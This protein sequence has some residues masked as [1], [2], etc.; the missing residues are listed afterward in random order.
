MHIAFLNPQGNFDANDSYW[1]EHADFGGQLVYVKN[2]AL[3]LAALGHSVDIVTRQV[4]DSDWPEFSQPQDGYA[5]VEGLRI[6]RIP[7]GGD[8]FVRKEDLWPFLATEWVPGIVEFYGDGPPDAATAHYGDGGIAAALLQEHLGVPY[9][10]TAHSLGA[11]KLDKLLAS[12][13]SLED[14]DDRYLFRR[15][16]AAERSAIANASVVITS[17]AQER[18]QQYEHRAYRSPASHERFQVVPP[19]VSLEVFDVDARAANESEV[20]GKLES[21]LADQIDAGRLG[22]PAVVASSRLDP[23]KNPAVLIDALADPELREMANLVFVTG[24][25]EDPLHSDEGAGPTEAAVLADMRS[26]I[27]LHR[28]EG[29]VAAVGVRGQGGLAAVYRRLAAGDGVFALTALYEPFGLAPLE[30]AASGL[31]VVATKNGGPSESLVDGTT[32]YGI[33]A[34]PTDPADIAAGIKRALRDHAALASAGRRRVLDTYTWDRTARGYV[35]AIES[36]G[37]DHT[38]P[39][40]SYFAGGPDV[41]LAELV[42]WMG[43]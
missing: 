2:V 9:T 17:T 28:L 34:D 29:A 10:F 21:R 6:V 35:A 13:E 37:V 12:G 14:L 16:L 26:R 43:L 41:T 39:V 27:K 38:E 36:G 8:R 33:L 25:L 19:G 32:E 1:S 23:K 18:D 24:A 31:A 11:Q 5:G 30:A 7:C 15:R 22:L 3:A 40:H 20:I 42:T 4:I